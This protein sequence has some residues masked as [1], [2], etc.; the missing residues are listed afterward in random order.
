MEKVTMTEEQK[1]MARKLINLQKASMERMLKYIH[2]GYYVIVMEKMDWCALNH[3]T[4][5]FSE[6]DDCTRFFETEKDA[7]LFAKGATYR[8]GDKVVEV[9]TKVVTC[10]WAASRKYEI[11]KLG[12]EMMENNLKN[13]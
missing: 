8:N 12:I 4:K 13:Q 9:K 7:E 2:C 3:K 10:A 11:D 5:M 6:V 1:G